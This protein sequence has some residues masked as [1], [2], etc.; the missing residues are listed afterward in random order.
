MALDYVRKSKVIS[1]GLCK[2]IQRIDTLTYLNTLE[3]I[4]GDSELDNE[5]FD[6]LLNNDYKDIEEARKVNLAS[7]KRTQRLRQRIE[8]YLSLGE[9][10]FL[11]LTFTDKVLASTN[12]QSRKKYVSKC[13]KMMSNYYV[14]NVD[15]GKEN[16]REHYHAL[17]VADKVSQEMWRYGNLD[18]QRVRHNNKSIKALPKYINKLT[19]HAIKETTKRCCMIYS[20]KVI[21]E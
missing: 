15:Y 18:W 10:L 17:I 20:K 9:C 5:Y 7:F 1:S 13:L 14:A 3:G 11:T 6:I 21:S 4:V 12:S 16:E 8:E 2:K 19:N